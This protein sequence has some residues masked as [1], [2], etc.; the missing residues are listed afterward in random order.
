[1]FNPCKLATCKKIREHGKVEL[2]TLLEH[3]GRPQE[4]V[5]DEEPFRQPALVDP[6]AA[7]DEGDNVKY[8]LQRLGKLH[9]KG[10]DA[11]HAYLTSELA[12]LNPNITILI[13]IYLILPHNTACCE[14]GFSAMNRIKTASRNRLYVTTLDALMTVSL[15]GPVLSQYKSVDALSL[16]QVPRR[17]QFL[18]PVSVQFMGAS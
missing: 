9:S 7:R 1:M 2:K 12:P 18:A 15:N 6:D 5:A 13:Q 16:L 17:C 8:E 4:G 14:R 3:Y 11:L 10:N